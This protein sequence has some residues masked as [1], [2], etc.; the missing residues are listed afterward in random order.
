MYRA[1]NGNGAW[2]N[3]RG[4]WKLVV[5]V[6]SSAGNVAIG[7]GGR[8]S[9]TSSRV[10]DFEIIWAAAYSD[11]PDATKLEELYT[12]ARAIANS[13]S[14]KIDWRDCS[15]YADCVLLWGQSNADG[16]ALVS[17]LSAGD[18]ARIYSKVFLQG[19]SHC[20]DTRARRAGR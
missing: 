15:D 13:K 14:H 1:A 6:L 7:F 4:G 3:N 19:G 10:S 8:V 18:Q 9:A 17:D 20:F 16:R 5:R 11:A 12:A 2:E